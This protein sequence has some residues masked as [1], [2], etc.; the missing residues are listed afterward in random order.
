MSK[1]LILLCKFWIVCFGALIIICLFGLFSGFVFAVDP[2]VEYD[3]SNG[4]CTLKVP[5]EV[6]VNGPGMHYII[7]IETDIFPEAMQN[8]VEPKT[9]TDF[10]DFE[11]SLGQTPVEPKTRTDFFGPEGP[12][13]QTPLPDAAYGDLVTKSA[14]Q[15]Q[16]GRSR[17]SRGIGRGIGRG[18]GI[19]CGRLLRRLFCR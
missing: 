19:G 15:S 2:V 14:C 3:C 7:P 9:R 13:G 8:P 12:L 18:C 10:F 17:G 4:V 16:C 5:V 11:N 6:E 1:L